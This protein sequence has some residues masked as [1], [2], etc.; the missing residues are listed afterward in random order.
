MAT[1]R[2]Q[3]AR[4][5]RKPRPMEPSLQ[6]WRTPAYPPGADQVTREQAIALGDMRSELTRLSLQLAGHH[7]LWG[8]LHATSAALEQCVRIAVRDY[9]RYG[10]FRDERGNR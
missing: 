8:A 10:R 1:K 9:D 7:E 5:P 2:Q 6:P 3:H 4:S